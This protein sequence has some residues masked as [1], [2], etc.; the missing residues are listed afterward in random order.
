ML[1][2]ERNTEGKGGEEKAQR[3]G[4]QRVEKAPAGRTIIAGMRFLFGSRAFGLGRNT[5]LLGTS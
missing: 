1:V 4:R 5:C 3:F 2:A